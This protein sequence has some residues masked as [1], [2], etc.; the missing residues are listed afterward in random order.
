MTEEET[1]QG[2][3]VGVRGVSLRFD[4][5]P[6]L[7]HVDLTVSRGEIVTVIGPNGAGKS[8][9]L[10]V[11]LG[12]QK[13]VAGQL[14]RVADLRIGYMPQRIAVDTTLPLTVRRFLSLGGRVAPGTRQA[15]LD[16]LGVGYL[17]DKPFQR[18]S[19]GE[20][21]RVLLAR[22][23]LR[24]PDLLVLDEP[25]Q[26]LD[27]GGQPEMYELIRTLR[28][29]LGCGV[30]MVSHDL[31]L[32]MAA[33]DR[34]VCLNHHV[35]CT[36]HPHDVREHPEYIALFP[37]EATAGLGVYTHHHDHSHAPAGDVMPRPDGEPH[38]AG[39]TSHEG[40]RHG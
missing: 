33:T 2:V 40:H 37:A 19:G 16:E 10:R 31:H 26:N 13:P 8:T 11:V 18:V 22:A 32:V 21:Q 15:V 6:V 17:L 30:L 38:A 27:V 4:G 23:A 3:L 34:V 28:D 7:D 29:R 14:E 24:A 12:L 36:G 1:A 20:M 9:L 5:A 35:C 39:G 25:A